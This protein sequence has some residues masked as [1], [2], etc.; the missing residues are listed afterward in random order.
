MTPTEL[1]REKRRATVRRAREIVQALSPDTLGEYAVPLIHKLD[2]ACQQKLTAGREDLFGSVTDLF[3]VF[4]ALVTNC[5][6][7]LGLRSTERNDLLLINATFQEFLLLLFREGEVV[8][9]G[10]RQRARSRAFEIVHYLR[11]LR[12]RTHRGEKRGIAPPLVDMIKVEVTKRQRPH[13]S[14]TIED[15]FDVDALDEIDD[16]EAGEI[17]RLEEG[18]YF[19]VEEFV[20]NAFERFLQKAFTNDGVFPRFQRRAFRQL[21]RDGLSNEV[22]RGRVIAAGTGFGKTEA[23]LLPILYFSCCRW[24]ARGRRRI[25]GDTKFVE[26]V[27][28]LLLYPRRD[29]CRVTC[30]CCV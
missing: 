13:R 4:H 29:L 1:R 14:E 28:A 9:V 5:G 17:L 27:N 30:K 25:K 3:P 19:E 7:D 15:M 21:I 2:V 18:E 20:N 12:Q 16:G 11:H 23:F 6:E 22:P 24:I 10:D 26:G 8:F